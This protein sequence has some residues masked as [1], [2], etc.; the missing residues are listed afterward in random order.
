MTTYLP[1]TGRWSG[2][3]SRRRL[4]DHKHR[5][6]DIFNFGCINFRFSVFDNRDQKEK[7]VCFQVR[8]ILGNRKRKITSLI[9]NISVRY[10]F[11]RMQKSH[12]FMEKFHSIQRLRVRN[13]IQQVII[14]EMSQNELCRST[15][16]QNFPTSNFTIRT[17]A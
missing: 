14:D 3:C 12:S 15:E 7:F 6:S 8:L 4:K 11:P 13:K 10:T 2:I 5:T 17:F 16:P 1:P 9:P